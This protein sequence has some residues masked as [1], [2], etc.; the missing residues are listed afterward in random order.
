MVKLSGRSEGQPSLWKIRLNHKKPRSIKRRKGI[1]N[2]KENETQDR[3][4][5]RSINVQAPAIPKRL[6]TCRCL[7][8]KLRTRMLEFWIPWYGWFS[9]CLRCGREWGNGERLALPFAPGVG[10]KNVGKRNVEMA[11]AHWRSI[12]K[13]GNGV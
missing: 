9:T 5:S 1:K 12:G 10:K 3:E 8:C 11:K 6:V 13:M 2:E 4:L 7:D